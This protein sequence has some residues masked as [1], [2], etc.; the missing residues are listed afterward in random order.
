MINKLFYYI[1]N[2]NISEIGDWINHNDLN[3]TFFVTNQVIL[4]NIK[5]IALA[6]QD[7]DVIHLYEESFTEQKQEF[8]DNGTWLDSRPFNFTGVLLSVMG[9]KY[10]DLESVITLLPQTNLYVQDFNRIKDCYNLFSELNITSNKII[11]G[12]DETNIY[13]EVT[14]LN[15]IGDGIHNIFQSFKN[16]LDNLLLEE[17]DLIDEASTTD[18]IQY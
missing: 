18:Y 2:N 1:Y 10:Q 17:V 12:A 11:I 3:D 6:E 9:Y 7:P 14:L 8:I 16:D 4:D 13:D 5:K 15:E